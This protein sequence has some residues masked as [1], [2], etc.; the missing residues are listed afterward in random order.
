MAL[1]EQD[2]QPKTRKQQADE[3]S[4]ASP[5]LLAETQESLTPGLIPLNNL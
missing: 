3:P 4:V 1:A 2:W 5:A